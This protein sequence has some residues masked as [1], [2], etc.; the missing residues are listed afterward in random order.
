MLDES[1]QAVRGGVEWLARGIDSWFGDRPF[2]PERAVRDGR[3]GIRTSWREDEGF[4]YGL[5]FRA[6]FDPPNL[7]ERAFVFIGRDVERDIVTDTPDTLS[8]AEQLE[9]VEP[10]DRA[11]FV[12]L[13]KDLSDYVQLRA[14]VRGGLKF[15][16]Q[17]RY[18]RLWTLSVRDRL[19]FRETLYWTSDDRLGTTTTVSADHAFSPSL[20]LRW[21]NSG[22]LSQETDGFEW[23]SNLGL[24]KSFGP[25]TLLSAEAL[26]S[27]E[28][29]SD[30]AVSDYGLRV[31]WRQPLYR[32][33]LLG[34]F[35]VG[36]FWPRENAQSPRIGTPAFGLSVEM[37]F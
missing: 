24:Y 18:E 17:A 6:R 31:T 34:E 2:D 29:G 15:Y 5:R 11:F 3:L 26:I 35:I 27:G 14:G 9:K 13:G 4:D 8:R 1:R 23:S 37:R 21:L 30:I 33:W 10:E 12:G 25:L 32:D 7:R 16:A 28:T 19:R 22:T 36:Y 20:A